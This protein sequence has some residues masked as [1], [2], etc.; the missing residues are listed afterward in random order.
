MRFDEETR[1]AAWLA[2]PREERAMLVRAL[3]AA[4]DG[5]RGSTLD[6]LDRYAVARYRR[7]R[8]AHADAARDARRRVLV[9]ARLDRGT[10]DRVRAAADAR[11]VS[12][13]RFVREAVE[14]ELFR[15]ESIC[16]TMDGVDGPGGGETRTDV[17]SS[18]D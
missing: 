12:V 5:R 1:R 15:F 14:R 11:G 2:M 18:G 9:G 6:A 17:P 16:G 8:K 10:A 7:G 13:Y 3:R 4:L